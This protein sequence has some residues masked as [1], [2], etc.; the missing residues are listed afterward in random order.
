M[1]QCIEFAKEQIKNWKRHLSYL[2]NS[3]NQ[4]VREGEIGPIFPTEGEIKYG[5]TGDDLVYPPEDQT[6]GN[7]SDIKQTFKK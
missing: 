5:N 6:D 7:S 3:V 1:L 2:E 4:S